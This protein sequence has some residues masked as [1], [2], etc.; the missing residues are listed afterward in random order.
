MLAPSHAAATV[1]VAFAVGWIVHY[2]SVFHSIAQIQ[3][4]LTAFAAGFLL[5]AIA[6]MWIAAFVSA[7]I[8]NIP[9][10][11]TM[12]PIVLALAA[13]GAISLVDVGE[14]GRQHGLLEIRGGGHPGQLVDDQLVERHPLRPG[15][16]GQRLVER[17]RKT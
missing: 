1:M 14:L 12:I 8:D 16:S 3:G 4:F 11:V 2:E 7:I 10:T 17:F 9:F 5:T 6:L 15:S 13:A